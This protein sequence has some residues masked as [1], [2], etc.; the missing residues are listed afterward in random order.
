MTDW[1]EMEKKYYMQTN[2]RIP[3][4]L[5]KGEGMKVWDDTGKEYLDCVGGLAV[6]SLGHC[7]PVVVTLSRSSHAR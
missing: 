2:I 3:V 1:Q 5:V 4:T 6:N 7:H